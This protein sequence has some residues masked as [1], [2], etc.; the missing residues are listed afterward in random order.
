MVAL[1]VLRYNII[2]D[3]TINIV[4]KFFEMKRKNAVRELDIYKRA[5]NQIEKHSEFYKVCKT[6][7][8]WRASSIIHTDWGSLCER[9][10]KDGKGKGYAGDRIKRK[11]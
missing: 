8:I 5:T 2:T 7:H 11:S 6:I 9:C 10:S 3:G 1:G 4:D